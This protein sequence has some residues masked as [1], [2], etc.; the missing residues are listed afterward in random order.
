MKRSRAGVSEL[1]SSNSRLAAASDGL[2]YAQPALASAP[3]PAYE[4]A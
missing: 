3:L 4:E 2:R 1:S